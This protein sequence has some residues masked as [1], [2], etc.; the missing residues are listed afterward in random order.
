MKSD[1][2]LI[3]HLKDSVNKYDLDLLSISAKTFVMHSSNW[4]EKTTQNTVTTKSTATCEGGYNIRSGPGTT[5]GKTGYI[6]SRKTV[7]LYSGKT[8]ADD[9]TGGYWY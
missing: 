8:A 7:T 2:K 9:N 6:S 1:P 3:V 5:H 4:G